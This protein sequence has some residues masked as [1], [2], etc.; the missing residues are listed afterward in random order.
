MRNRVDRTPW[1]CAAIVAVATLHA[2]RPQV[3]AA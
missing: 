3:V 2:A 1:I